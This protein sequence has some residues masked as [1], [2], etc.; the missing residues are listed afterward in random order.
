MSYSLRIPRSLRLCNMSPVSWRVYINRKLFAS[1]P[2]FVYSS[3]YLSIYPSI[4]LSVCPS[5]ITQ[6]FPRSF[7]I[8]LFQFLRLSKAKQTQSNYIYRT[9]KDVQGVIILI[10][11]NNKYCKKK[12]KK[13]GRC[14]KITMTRCWICGIAIVRE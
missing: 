6:S 8:T 14:F 5:L 10:L 12:K 2:L 1:I 3:T 7:T 9:R 11:S 4:Y 13:N